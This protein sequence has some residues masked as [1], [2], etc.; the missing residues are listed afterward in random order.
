MVAFSDNYGHVSEIA[1]NMSKKLRD[2]GL[3]VDIVD[4]ERTKQSR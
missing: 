4:L 1:D 3:I 2:S